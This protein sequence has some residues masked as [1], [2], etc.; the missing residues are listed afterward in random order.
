MKSLKHRLERPSR[1]GPCEGSLTGRRKLLEHRSFF[2]PL[3]GATFA[4]FVHTD[5]KSIMLKELAR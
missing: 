1:L 5:C 3:P 2:P 4:R